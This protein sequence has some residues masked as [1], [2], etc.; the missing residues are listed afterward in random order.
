MNVKREKK[1]R[2]AS[3]IPLRVSGQQKPYPA[4]NDYSDHGKLV[5]KRSSRNKVGYKN[6]QAEEADPLQC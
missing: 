6:N 5:Y 3:V 4:E 2:R 1:L